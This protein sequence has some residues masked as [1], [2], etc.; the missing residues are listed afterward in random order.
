ML[1]NGNYHHLC[2]ANNHGTPP[3]PRILRPWFLDEAPKQIM[4][5]NFL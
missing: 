5:H 3:P 4:Y 2:Q 1:S